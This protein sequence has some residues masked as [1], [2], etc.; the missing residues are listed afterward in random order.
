MLAFAREQGVK[1]AGVH[2][3]LLLL[4]SALLG[5]AN[6]LL[7]GAAYTPYR[8][9]GACPDESQVYEDMGRVMGVTHRVRLYSTECAAVN[10]ILLRYAS[11]GKLEILMGV[12]IDNR[13]RDQ[14]EI[15]DLITALR[16]FPHARLTGIVVGNEVMY[17]NTASSSQLAGRIYEVRHKVRALGAE[18]GSEV[19]KTT[20]VYAVEAYPNAQLVAASDAL[21][22]NIH[23][24]YVPDLPN[25]WD[26]DQ[27]ADAALEMATKVM[28]LF[29]TMYPWKPL[30]VTEIGWPTSSSY[31]DKH[32]GNVAIAT[33]FMWKWK[34]HAEINNIP[35][36]YFEVFDS[37]WR[38][39]LFP[40][41][42]PSMSD[43]NFG[44]FYPDRKTPK[45]GM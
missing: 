35:Y 15:D 8:H 31:S 16:E 45:W 43:F 22:V 34:Y 5:Q 12:W 11:E 7:F 21:G 32:V 14:G 6:G 3:G 28:N 20:P 41:D 9:F 29:K 25:I 38:H 42:N 27:M 30:V 40:S 24:F 37:P 13:S 10:R 44:L 4:L 36:Y 26:P 33:A 19:L 17:R 39:P 23:P 18:T 1:L 2:V